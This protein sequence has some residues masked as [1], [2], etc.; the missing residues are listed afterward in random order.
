M[1]VDKM[2]VQAIKFRENSP[3]KSAKE[4]TEMVIDALAV[5][6]SETIL[7]PHRKKVAALLLTHF[8]PDWRTMVEELAVVV[9]R[10]DPLVKNWR[11]AVLERDNHT[12]QVC[13][14]KGNHAH[15]QIQWADSPVDRIRVENGIT[16]CVECH[17][18]EHEDIKNLILSKGRRMVI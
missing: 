17:A 6:I 4:Q 2:I 7:C 11:K 18:N 3:I 15:H 9:K 5:I 10:N 14:N 12:C 13:G 16:L 8:I 1:R